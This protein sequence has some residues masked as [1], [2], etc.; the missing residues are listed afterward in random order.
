MSMTEA[1]GRVQQIQA[2]LAELSPKPTGALAFAD[3]LAA[4]GPA[5]RTTATG[6]ALP[7]AGALTGD[8]IVAAAKQYLGVPYVFG[9]EDAT[10]MDCS[11]LVQRALADLGVD[12]P[13]LVSGQ[14]TLGT[15]VP[16]LAEAKPGDLIVTRGGEHIAI[17][18]GDDKIIHAP[19]PGKDVRI[20][21][22]YFDDSDIVTIRRVAPDA[23]APVVGPA[24]LSGLS[25]LN[26]L[27][28][29]GA[30]GLTGTGSPSITDLIASAQSA[31]AA[32]LAGQTR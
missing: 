21:D 15:E 24:G 17:Y 11:G 18:L 19:R 2:T 3:A 13:R 27:T 1:I 14:S 23:P 7:G 26:G 32:L 12:V 16:S 9:G 10:G 4:A 25:G 22:V 8:A 29:L 20:V 6:A 28:G 5:S 31:K 30:S